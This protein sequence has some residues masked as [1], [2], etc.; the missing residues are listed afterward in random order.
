ML[1]ASRADEIPEAED[2]P[3]HE[4]VAGLAPDVQVQVAKVGHVGVYETVKRCTL[5]FKSIDHSI[6]CSLQ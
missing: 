1:L 3:A 6:E 2:D 4:D 5:S